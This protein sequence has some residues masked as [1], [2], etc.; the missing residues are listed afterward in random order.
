MSLERETSGRA[1]CKAVV[2]S[3]LCPFGDGRKKDDERADGDNPTSTM[4]ITGDGN[5]P[6]EGGQCGYLRLSLARGPQVATSGESARAENKK[7]EFCVVV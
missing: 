3:F 1:H 5:A 4:L 7:G 6:W 2:G